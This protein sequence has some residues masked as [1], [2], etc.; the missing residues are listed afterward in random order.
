[1]PLN[2]ETKPLLESG[3]KIVDFLTFL[4]LQIF[5]VFVIMESLYH[6]RFVN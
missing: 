2:K 1:M 4:K 5:S 6:F 3:V